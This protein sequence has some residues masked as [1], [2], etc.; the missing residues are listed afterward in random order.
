MKSSLSLFVLLASIAAASQ[1]NPQPKPDSPITI[2]DQKDF[3]KAQ[4]ALL[5]SQAA[6]QAA[7]AQVEADQKT[8]TELVTKLRSKCPAGT[9]LNLPNGGDLVCQ[10]TPPEATP[11]KK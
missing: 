3:F 4:A 1:P 9:A 8:F 5:Q 2:A 6:F 10:P 11:A 7:K